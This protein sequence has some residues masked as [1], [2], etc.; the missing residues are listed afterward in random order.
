MLMLN[1]DW[2]REAKPA[3]KLPAISADKQH[4]LNFFLPMHLACSRVPARH[5][6]GAQH[7]LLLS[8]SHLGLWRLR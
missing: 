5:S 1:A 2:S 7:P 4:F 3:S 8:P 6:L